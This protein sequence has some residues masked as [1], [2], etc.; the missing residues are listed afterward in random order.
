MVQLIQFC[1][2]S[3][4]SKTGY[5]L[6]SFSAKFWSMGLSSGSSFA[7]PWAIGTV[8]GTIAPFR[9]SFFELGIDYGMI[10][11]VEDV[12]QYYSLYPFIH[13]ALFLPFKESGGWYA[14]AGVGYMT[15]KYTFPE[16]DIP[17][18]I[19]AVDVTAGVNFWDM[20]DVSYTL[21]TNFESA[22]HKIAVGYTYRFK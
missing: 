17:V 19:F 8:R 13:A 11:G 10:S 15:G 1:N 4:I 14:G 6:R 7:V 2:L 12:E 18:N 20:L 22:N 5:F 3:F 9:N 21:R 16:G